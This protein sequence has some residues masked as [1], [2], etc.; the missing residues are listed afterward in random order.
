M[1]TKQVYCRVE[2]MKKDHTTRELLKQFVSNCFSISCA[3]NF[4]QHKKQ[5]PSSLIHEMKYKHE[6]RQAFCVFVGL[7]CSYWSTSGP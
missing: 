6:E 3:G 5:L 2:E 7:K 4:S 1:M